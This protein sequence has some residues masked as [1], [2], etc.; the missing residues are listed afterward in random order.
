MAVEADAAIADWHMVTLAQTPVL[1]GFARYIHKY[2]G[3]RGSCRVSQSIQRNKR[4]LHTQVA[5]D[6]NKAVPRIIQ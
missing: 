4:S 3:S 6:N 1:L 2:S 5:K